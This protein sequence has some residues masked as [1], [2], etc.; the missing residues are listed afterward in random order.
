MADQNAVFVLTVDGTRYEIALSRLTAEDA[1]DFR[2]ATGMPLQAVFDGKQTDIDL[3]AG[4]IWL[5]RKKTDRKLTY[6][7]VASGFSYGTDV[8]VQDGGDETVDPTTSGG[9]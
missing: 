9:N 5:V 2:A 4:L 8:D 1:R 7:Q 3:I 6:H